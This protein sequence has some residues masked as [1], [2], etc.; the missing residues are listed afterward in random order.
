MGTKCKFHNGYQVFSS[1]PQM[2]SAGGVVTT[3]QQVAN[4]NTETAVLTETIPANTLKD[5]GMSFRVYLAGEISS[6]GTGDCT[7]TLRYGTTDIVAVATVSLL[8]EDDIPFALEYTGHILTA[9]ATGKVVST[10]RFIVYQAGGVLQFADDTA[11]TGATVNLTQEGA[12]NV[13]AHWDAASADNDVIV[14]H[15]WIEFYNQ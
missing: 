11:N 2:I 4:S 3:N 6:T 10:G 8:D 13:T 15:G 14:T 9:G 1:K 12:L 7:F 5:T